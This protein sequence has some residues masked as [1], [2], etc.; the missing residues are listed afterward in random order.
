MP[1]PAAT[2]EMIAAYQRDGYI[3]VENAIDPADL[4]ELMSIC[5]QML[6][7]KDKYG[8]KDWAWKEGSPTER[9]FAI[10]QVSPSGFFPQLLESKWYQWSRSFAASLMGMLMDFWYDQFLAKPPGFGAP[11][12]WHQDEGYWGGA[13]GDKGVTCWMPFHDVNPDNGCM[14]FIPGGHRE[15]ILTHRQSE[16]VKSDLLMCEVDES[17]VVAAPLKLGSVT[18]HH[19]KMPH[20][21]TGNKTQTWRRILAQHF[22]P[23]Q[24]K[25]EGEHYPWKV[26]VDQRTGVKTPV[27]KQQG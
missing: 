2:E 20:M 25:G 10:V 1:Y 5:E 8:A 22:K 16:G 9:K 11:T 17:R 24:V 4:Q 26:S 21:T 7:D 15:G 14:H 6:D 19:S 18:F 23:P 12:P 27:I 13:L 3:I